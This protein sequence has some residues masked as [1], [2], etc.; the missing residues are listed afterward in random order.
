FL[1]GAQSNGVENETAKE[2]WDQLA[3]FAGF[4]FCKSHAA[5]FALLAYQTLYLKA[6]YPAEYFC[7]LLNHQP[8]GFYPPE[9]LVGDARRRGVDVLGPDVNRSLE[10]CTLE[11]GERGAGNQGIGNSGVGIRLGLGYVRGLGEAWQGRIVER[12]GAASFRDLVDFCRRTRLPRPV[13]ENLVRAGALDAFGRRRDLL[14]ALGGLDYREEGLDLAVPVAPVALPPLADAERLA[15]EYELL[16]LAPGAH[17]MELYREALRKQGVL[18]SRELARRRA[19]ARVRV[20]GWAVVR[21]RPPTARGMLFVTLEDE[22]GLANLVVR[23]D[24]YDRYRDALRNAPL[25]WVEGQVQREGEAVS[26]L[27]HRAA[28]LVP[29]SRSAR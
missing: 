5:A 26:V 7:A 6:H 28:A 27:V 13:V 14:W 24:V 1:A 17:V 10:T 8:L 22:E 16:G 20:A 21:Q 3:A 11:V 23:R 18:T 19:G 12:R 9:V 15:W 25:L 29:N 4:G 2:I